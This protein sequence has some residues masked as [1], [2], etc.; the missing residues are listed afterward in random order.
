M[1]TI[2]VMSVSIVLLTKVRRLPHLHVPLQGHVWHCT[3]A[4]SATI[5]ESSN[6]YYDADETQATW[7]SVQ[8]NH[9][10]LQRRAIATSDK[11]EAI[12]GWPKGS[13]RKRVD[14]AIQEE[15]NIMQSS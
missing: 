9:A 7:D 3:C 1:L 15:Q 14:A 4:L 11:L 13:Y 6:M 2:S 5:A 10:Q 8:S 12:C